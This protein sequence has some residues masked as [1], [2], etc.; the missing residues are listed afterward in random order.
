MKKFRNFIN[1]KHVDAADGS[2]LDIINPATGIPALTTSLR[3]I[4]QLEATLTGKDEHGDAQTALY[5]LLATL[6]HDDH[7]LAVD[8]IAQSDH[9][10]TE[11]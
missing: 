7:A 9:P 3:G 1:G 11:E 6:I 10:E 2:T 5:K 8:A 4:I